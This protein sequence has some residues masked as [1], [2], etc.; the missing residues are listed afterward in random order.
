[1]LATAPK[2]AA[3]FS[4]RP[5]TPADAD[6]IWEIFHEV[7]SKGDTYVFAP[8]TSR[9]DADA[10]WL[11]PD[12]LNYVATRN[13]DGKI[14][15]AYVVRTNRPG[16][17]SHV[18]NASYIVHAQARGLGVGRALGE[19]AI[20]T[21][22]NAGYKAMQYNFVVSTNEKAVALWKSLGYSVIGTAP[23]GYQHATLGLVD[24]LIMHRFL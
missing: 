17:G 5:A 19:H 15:G 16:L 11:N 22:R 13:T 23:K 20:A 12:A 8:D 24:V 10:Y 14:L 4:I 7:I 3:A 1:M 9:A 2:P 6:G 21:A 18:A